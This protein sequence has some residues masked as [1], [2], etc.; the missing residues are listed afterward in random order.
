MQQ[1]HN[2]THHACNSKTST[3]CTNHSELTR[4]VTFAI[5]TQDIMHVSQKQIL[6]TIILG[7]LLCKQSVYY[8][9]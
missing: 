7:I 4:N 9:K 1:Y 6:F 3:K 2:A 8:E 5:K